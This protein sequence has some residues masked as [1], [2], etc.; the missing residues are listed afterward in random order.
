MNAVSE[1]LS[2]GCR[3][4]IP[5]GGEL[6]WSW[7]LAL[8]RT[9]AM[10]FTGPNPISYSE[11]EAYARLH[12]WPLE[13]RHVDLILAMDRA[14]LEFNQARREAPRTPSADISPDLFDAVF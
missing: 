10:G 5:D 7:F 3:P 1:S 12:R 4:Q 11:I 6:A 2:A 8:N 13:K 14:Y 9:R